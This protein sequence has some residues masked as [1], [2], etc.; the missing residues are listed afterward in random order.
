MNPLQASLV[1]SQNAFVSVL[2]VPS[3]G[4]AFNM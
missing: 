2:S 1:G 3:S 4:N